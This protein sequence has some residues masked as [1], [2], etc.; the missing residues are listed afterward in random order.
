MLS[1]LFRVENQR[2][3]EQLWAQYPKSTELRWQLERCSSAVTN[4]QQKVEQIRHLAK[5]ITPKWL[6]Y[7]A[8]KLVEPG[9]RRSK[10]LIAFEEHVLKITTKEGAWR[11]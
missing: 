1:Q 7:T 3:R 5:F 8:E 11:W 6:I 9:K 10:E 4:P 2:L